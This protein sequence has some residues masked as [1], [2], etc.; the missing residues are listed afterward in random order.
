MHKL[1]WQPHSQ[2]FEMSNTIIRKSQ[3]TSFQTKLLHAYQ[4]PPNRTTFKHL[5]TATIQ[6]LLRSKSC[7]RNFQFYRLC[8]KFTRN[9]TSRPTTQNNFWKKQDQAWFTSNQTICNSTK[10]N[11]IK[12]EIN[13]SKDKIKETISNPL[14]SSHQTNKHTHILKKIF[15][16]RPINF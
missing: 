16:N 7:T 11:T 9:S 2:L 8:R 6:A 5:T 1:R 15:L 4:K 10:I 12:E 14:P 13:H 3:Q